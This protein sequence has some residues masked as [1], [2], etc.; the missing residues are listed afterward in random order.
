[1]N[2]PER[3]LSALATPLLQEGGWP[4]ASLPEHVAL[5]KFDR[6]VSMLAWAYNEEDLVEGFLQRAVALL[7]STV[8]DWEIVIVDDCSTDRTN[9]IVT[10]FA[11]REPRIRLVRHERNLNVG[12]AC[13]T[14]IANARKEFLFWQTVDWS[15][16]IS[17]LRIF[18]ELLK[19]FDAVQGIR[20]VPIRLLSYIPVLRSIYRIRRR[21]D[22]F[23]KAIISLGNYYLLTIL[24]GARFHDF[25][26]VTFYRIQAVRGLSI[27]GRTSFVNPELLLKSYYSGKRFIEV[28]IRFVSRQKGVA[29]GTRPSV[30]ARS[31][32]DTARNWILWGARHRLSRA[33]R[34]PIRRVS[35]P[36]QLDQSTLRLVLPLFDDFKDVGK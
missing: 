9:A 1:M 17:K 5:G 15:Y 14:A 21:S 32:F 19:H 31:M 34:Q 16:D 12:M 13:R 30:V 24:F 7:E 27:I 28:P 36:F 20:P 4:A 3:R 8:T 11:T 10:A 6:G 22:S 18:L 25:Q 23:Y 35:E 29:K 33:P 26:N 2:R